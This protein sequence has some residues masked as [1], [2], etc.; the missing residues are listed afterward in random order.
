MSTSMLNPQEFLDYRRFLLEFYR[1][2]C[3][4]N[5]HFS[6]RLL[7]SKLGMDTSQLHRILNGKL[8][9]PLDA[10]PRVAAY[11]ELDTESTQLFERRVRWGRASLP[12]MSVT[13][14]QRSGSLKEIA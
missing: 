11:L 10:I 1:M 7:A 4:A 8:H 6:Y 14:R 12:C 9:L 5:P 13:R 2:K 3:E